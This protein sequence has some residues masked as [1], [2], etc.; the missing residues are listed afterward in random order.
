MNSNIKQIIDELKLN[1][2][3][4]AKIEI[5]K[6]NSNNELLGRVLSFCYDRTKWT[7]GVKQIPTQLTD[8]TNGELDITDGLN[9]LIKLNDRIYTGHAALNEI[10]NL[11]INMNKDDASIL[12][13][14]I[15]RDLKCGLGRTQINKVFKEL[16]IDIP[17]MRC[18]TYNE[19]T[20][21]SINFPAILQLKADGMYQAVTVDNGEVTF[22]S[23]SGEVREFPLLR[24][25]FSGLENG[26]YIGELLINGI[27]NRAEANGLINSD[28]TPQER[29][30]MQL[31]DYLTIQE[32]SDSKHA[33]IQ[34]VRH[35]YK[36]RLEV[37]NQ[38]LLNLTLSN[39]TIIKTDI[40][41]DISEALKLTSEYMNEGYEGSILKDMSNLFKD[42]TSK[43]QLKLKVKIEIDV[44][45]TGFTAGTKGTKRE[46]TFGAMTFR[47]D[48]GTIIGQCSGFNDKQLTDFNNR[49]DE[50]IGKIITVECNDITKSISN[51]YHALSHPRFQ[52]IRDDKETTD[53]LI[54]AFEL[55]DLSML[56]NS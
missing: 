38:L 26:V 36:V 8:L 55:R 49:R 29:V 43:T 56:L 54:R 52:E 13:G 2:S 3:T 21:K 7:F 19:K 28:D 48:D 51:N 4:N 47:N 10:H 44:R 20:S 30:I 45:I 34:V 53:T 11:L 35:I 24:E 40:V 6:K 12:I 18:D 33:N 41:N 39:I 31:W 1:P 9:L 23:R 17:Y 27:T 37:L 16:I 15:G 46:A 14:I 25:Q 32:Y 50:L 42:H 5:L 22:T